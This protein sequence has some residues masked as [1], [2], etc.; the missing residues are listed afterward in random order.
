MVEA[1]NM[2]AAGAAGDRL[3]K[4]MSGCT[5]RSRWNLE[6]IPSKEITGTRPKSNQQ[7]KRFSFD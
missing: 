2:R 7:I 6:I 1:Y 3:Q 5:W 4:R